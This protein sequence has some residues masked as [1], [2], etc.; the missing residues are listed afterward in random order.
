MKTA[1]KPH[2]IVLAAYAA[3]LALALMVL[4]GYFGAYSSFLDAFSHFRVH[5]A[6]AAALLALVLL[7][8]RF[9]LTA[10]SVLIFAV[11]CLATLPASVFG[12]AAPVQAGSIAAANGQPIYRLLQMNLRFNNPAPEKVLS[13]IGSVQPDIITFEE[14]S[15]MWEDKLS[16]VAHAYPY[17]IRCGGEY[18]TTILSRRPFVE[19]S[20]P[21]C[22]ESG[23]LATARVD[24]G[25]TTVD[26]AAV[27]LGWPWPIR[28]MRQI[29]RISAPLAAF[30]DD[31]I[32]A[33]D[34]NAA[35]WSSA[36]HRLAGKGGFTIMP[37]VGATWLWRRLPDALRYFGLP[38]DQVFSKGG[39]TIH[40][41]KKLAPAGS[42][43]LPILVEFSVRPRKPQDENQ[44]ATVSAEPERTA[45]LGGNG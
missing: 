16:L 31:A 32:M 33:G 38:I 37:S 14:T 18:G 1:S 9:R 2:L 22:Y 15:Q 41:A 20:E 24:L 28:Q 3:M 5:F 19:G 44:T 13:L 35:A 27:H 30:G 42:D 21:G 34:C 43:H 6:A 8:T 36:V 45:R 11:A 17:G 4:A 7:A 29:D 12:L 25:G 10:G 39:V 26:V 23:T 40:S